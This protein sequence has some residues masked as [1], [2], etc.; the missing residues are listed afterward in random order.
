MKKTYKQPMTDVVNV[1]LTQLMAGSA[2]EDGFNMN[3]VPELGAGETSG[4]LSLDDLN[5]W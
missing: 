2:V 5:L 3:V 1:E 4:N